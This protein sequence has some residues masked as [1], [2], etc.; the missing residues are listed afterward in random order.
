MTQSLTI[1]I[2]QAAPAGQQPGGLFGNPM[3]FMVLMMVMMYFILIRPQR[4]KQ[5]D[6]ETL[7]KALSAGDE[8][9]TIGGAHG[10]VATVKEKTVVVK[11]AEGKVEF[12]RTAISYK[13]AKLEDSTVVEDK[14]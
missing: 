6:Q 8:V 3:V 7:Q 14:K 12:D 10:I 4:K 13:K 2:A 11:F 1:L 5:K 9:V